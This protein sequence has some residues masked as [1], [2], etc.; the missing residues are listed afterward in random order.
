MCQMRE[1]FTDDLIVKMLP[2]K[3]SYRLVYQ[4]ETV[5]TGISGNSLLT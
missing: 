3:N 4:L 1:Y 2:L 5:Q